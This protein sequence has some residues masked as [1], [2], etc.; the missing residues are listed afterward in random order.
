MKNPVDYPKKLLEPIAGFLSE[1]LHR[2]ER[3]RSEV[4]NEDPFK[5]AGRLSD[6][7]SL[8]TDA[9][10]QFGHARISAIRTELDRKIVQTRKALSMIK[11]GKYGVCERCGNMIDTDRLMVYP[12]V[13][14]CITCEKKRE[15]K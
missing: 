5:D 2:L 14:L 11:I 10:E 7:A 3:R 4:D 8:D 1:Q 15:K 13:T 6:N 9:A 12:E